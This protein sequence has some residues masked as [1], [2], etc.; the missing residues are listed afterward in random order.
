MK[1]LFLASVFSLLGA[2]WVLAQTQWN[3]SADAQ[4]NAIMSFPGRVA[5][6]Q[7][8]GRVVAGLTS[9]GTTQ[10][11]AL[12]LSG[13]GAGT[14]EFSTV[15]SAT[16]TALDSALPTGST[17]CVQ[18][19]GANTLYVYPPVGS[20]GAING[21][22]RYTLPINSFGCFTQTTSGGWVAGVPWGSGG[23]GAAVTLLGALGH[24]WSSG[25]TVAAGTFPL[26]FLPWSQYSVFQEIWG[27]VKGG[28]SPSFNVQLKANGSNLC[29]LTVN[30]GTRQTAAC[31][32]AAGQGALIEAVVSSVSGSPAEACVQVQ[33]LHAGQ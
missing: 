29:S 23:G 2:H 14:A 9:A 5:G 4:G 15:A 16:G 13:L 30:S 17:Q 7:W 26:G 31:A 32:A 1:T 24:C 25:E 22:S 11:T 19:D 6:W 18:D 10:N 20:S 21:A 33:A 3:S 12:D 28:S 8:S 27:I